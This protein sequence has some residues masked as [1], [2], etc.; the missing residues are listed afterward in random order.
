MLHRIFFICIIF[1]AIE[2]SSSDVI[3]LHGPNDTIYMY[4]NS[5]ILGQGGFGIVYKGL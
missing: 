1:T 5:S 3:T 2:F 4:D